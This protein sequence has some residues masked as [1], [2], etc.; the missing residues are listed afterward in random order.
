MLCVSICA[1]QSKTR[2]NEE[3]G[4]HSAARKQKT[5]NRPKN[6]LTTSEFKEVNNNNDDVP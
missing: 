2:F 4:T 5:E 6:H 3:S 1:T